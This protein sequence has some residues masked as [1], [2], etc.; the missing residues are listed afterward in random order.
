MNFTDNNVTFKDILNAGLVTGGPKIAKGKYKKDA[1]NNIT[2]NMPVVNAIDIDW[3]K[4]EVPGIDD[5]ITSTGQLLAIIGKVKQA[6]GNVNN[7][8]NKTILERLTAAEVA[9]EDLQENGGGGG[10]IPD[11]LVQQL[12]G[13]NTSI[14]SLE[15]RVSTIGTSQQTINNTLQSLNTR[16]SGIETEVNKF[17]HVVIEK[18]DYEKLTSYES[19]TLYFIIGEPDYIINGGGSSGGGSS[20][21]NLDAISTNLTINGQVWRTGDIVLQPGLTYQVSGTLRGHIII[22]TTGKTKDE[23]KGDDENPGIGN[24]E[25]I[26]SNVIINSADDSYAIYYKTPEENTGYQD[27]IVTVQKNTTNVIYCPTVKAIASNQ[28]GA[29]HSDNNLIIRGPGYLSIA[30]KGG[31]G[32]RGTEVEICGPHIYTDASHDGIHG[33]RVNFNYGYLYTYY[34]NDAIGTGDNGRINVF[35][36]HFKTI[37]LFE[38]SDTNGVLFDSK[39]P[40]LYNQDISIE[41]VNTMKNMYTLTAQNYMTVFGVSNPGQVVAYADKAAYTANRNPII[42]SGTIKNGVTKY[43]ID[44]TIGTYLAVT[45]II[46]HP[47]D[48]SYTN[49]TADTEC[50]IVLNNVFI[51]TDINTPTIYYSSKAGRLKLISTKDKFNIILNNNRTETFNPSVLSQDPA[52][53]GDAVKSENNISLEIKNNSHLFISSVFADGID[54]GVVKINDSKGYIII[55]CCG[56]RGIKGNAIIIGPNADVGESVISYYY[57]PSDTDKYATFD[58]V[59]IIKDN[60][61][62]TGESAGAQNNKTIGFAD[63]YAR[64]GKHKEKGAFGTRNNE[65]TGIILTGSIGAV[66]KIDMGNALNLYYNKIITPNITLDNIPN[67]TKETDFAQNIYKETVS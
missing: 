15:S 16:F 27:L 29:I 64:N 56:Q 43:Y 60:C 24:T 67:S 54:G 17:K 3:L 55:T 42:V 45:G 13:I 7:A 41:G 49:A 38:N 8:G 21:I 11:D 14:S 9:I 28:F 35:G 26:L 23:M 25:I 58:G 4:A 5:P 33:K 34:A 52:Y 50:T 20:R 61:V 18:E 47:I 40:G 1:N 39:T 12:N 6:V 66:V 19:N 46:S 30:N 57:T 31:H 48:I 2:G 53:E 51:T 22:D 44:T 10:E 59:A 62:Y 65:L 32:I 63:I 36:G 37:S